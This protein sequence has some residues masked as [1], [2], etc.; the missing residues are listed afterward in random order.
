MIISKVNSFIHK[1]GKITGIF[2][3]AVIAIPFVFMTGGGARRSSV[4]TIDPDQVVATFG[5][6][7]MTMGKL[8]QSYPRL[9]PSDFS[10]KF[11]PMI[12]MLIEQQVILDTAKEQGLGTVTKEELVAEIANTY[13]NF[14]TNGKFDFEK[15]SKVPTKNRGRLE[16]YIKE[17]MIR[18]RLTNK[19]TKQA[20][21]AITIDKMK[22]AF[23]KENRTLEIYAR[24]FKQHQ[25]NKET[26]VTK[27]EIKDYFTKNI[28]DFRIKEKKIINIVTFN[29]NNFLAKVK[30]TDKALKA[31]YEENKETKYHFGKVKASHILVKVEK[32][33]DQ[34]TVD[35]AKKKIEKIL[36]EV[37]AGKKSFSEIAKKSSEG[38]SAKRGG[39][40]GWFAK[41]RM[42][43]EFDKAIFIEKDGKLT[44]D[45]KMKVGEISGVIRTPFGFHIVKLDQ[46]PKSF[47]QIKKQVTNDFRIPE[48]KKLMEKVAY[49]FADKVYTRVMET[50]SPYVTAPKLFKDAAKEDKLEVKQSNPFSNGE[51]I[52]EISSEYFVKA[53]SKLDFSDP[54]SEAIIDR[55][56]RK[57]YVICIEKV[58]DSKL[59][60]LEKSQDVQRRI[61]KILIDQ[62]AK[63]LMNKAAEKYVTDLK[64]SLET[65]ITFDELVKQMK[66]KKIKPFKANEN[67][68]GLNAG[69]A[70]RRELADHNKG[71][72]VGPI[73]AGKG[74]D[75]IYIKEITL[76]TDKE[77][78]SKKKSFTA[79]YKTKQGQKAWQDYKTE[80]IE[81]LNIKF[82]SPFVEEKTKK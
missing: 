63:E 58:I 29:K 16:S 53:S 54:V 41:G 44:D 20:E 79:S 59:P 71:D 48:A 78:E 38:P 69:S 49:Q 39:S 46:L 36:A 81:K 6:T 21:A 2:I 61:R 56:G 55:T 66:L 62:K 67:P 77:F 45:V 37:K 25:F 76:P 19:V 7:E 9:R 34:K 17:K 82:F 4:K 11:Q 50:T 32:D 72:I 68:Q 60:E 5:G 28:E 30:V 80:L 43:P 22:S 14:A 70:V 42:V 8:M 15:Y 35:A 47:D 23:Q 27:D 40:L 74:I 26:K 64:A 18:E 51:S 13:P 12:K 57:A 52:P 65:K 10:P 1:H 24:T 33:A 75:V 73:K 31:F 3:L